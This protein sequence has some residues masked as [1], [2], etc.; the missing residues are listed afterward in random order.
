[1]M[2]AHVHLIA[3]GGSIMHNLALALHNQGFIVSGSDDQIFE[4]A[5]S[6]LKNA[7]ICPEK[8]GWD[9]ERINK[10]LSFIVLGMHAKKDNPELL[11]ALELDIPIYSFPSFIANAYAGQERIVIAGSHGKTTTTSMLMHVF[12]NLN[13][14]FDYLV[15][16]QLNGFQ[17]MVSLTRAKYAII[18][19]DEYLSSCLDMHPKFLHYKPKMAIIT[20]IAWDHYNVFPTYAQY[21]K[22]FEDFI[23]SIPEGGHLIYFDRDIELVDLVRKTA[24][25]LN[26]IPYHEA[27]YKI[28]DQA[29]YLIDDQESYAL[30]IFGKHNLQNMQA[31]IEVCRL[32]N[33]ESK[34]VYTAL[35]SFK[36]AAKRLQL[37]H[38]DLK[39]KVYQDFAHAPSKVRATLEAVSET[40][41]DTKILLYLELHTY[42]SLNAEFLP[43]Y[44]NAVNF[45]KIDTV[46][47]Y[48]EKALE[49]KSMQKMEDS[50]IQEAFGNKDIKV[51]H[52]TLELKNHMNEH[53]HHYPIVLFLGSGN[54]GGLKLQEIEF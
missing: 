40:F 14:S 13:Q 35:Q 25:H 5:L 39:R 23:L 26:C 37:I 38:S 31:V 28:I 22:A 1:M 30:E 20:G 42:S 44:R 50:Y 27:S 46:I 33:F 43:Q 3:I 21:I 34:S 2:N 10:K 48:D 16:A 18:E 36:G 29:T 53:I 45:R 52:R 4:P 47:F 12:K 17:E 24:G 6:R 54:W 8:I 7:G 41:P 51:I 11:K 49:L 32:L 9:P 19:G 15:G